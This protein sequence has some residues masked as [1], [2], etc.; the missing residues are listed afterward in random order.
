[1]GK[2]FFV[3]GRTSATASLLS[4][5]YLLNGDDIPEHPLV[6][7]DEAGQIRGYYDAT[8]YADTK[9]MMQDAVFLLMQEYVP[10]K[11]KK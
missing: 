4:E 9:K 5:S 8:S 11:E 10:R 6:L 2:W 1:P 3:S 7:L